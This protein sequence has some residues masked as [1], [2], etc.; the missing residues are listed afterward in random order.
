MSTED[1]SSQSIIRLRK[2]TVGPVTV[3]AGVEMISPGFSFHCDFVGGQFR[4]SKLG[5]V[6]LLGSFV[7]ESKDQSLAKDPRIKQ[8]LASAYVVW[9]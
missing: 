9:V 5:E 4:V 2:L 8:K 3:R 1:T 7:V 6:D